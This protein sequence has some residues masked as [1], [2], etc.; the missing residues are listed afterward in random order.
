[1]IPLSISLKNEEE[2]EERKKE[3]TMVTMVKFF[4]TGPRKQELL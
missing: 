1:M 4:S 3:T 2:E